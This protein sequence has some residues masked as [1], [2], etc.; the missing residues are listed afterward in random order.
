MAAAGQEI[1]VPAAPMSAVSA[2]PAAG[3]MQAKKDEDQ[4]GGDVKVSDK[5][6][7]SDS[8]PLWK[9][10]DGGEASTNATL[11]A[12]V[13]AVRKQ[14]LVNEQKLNSLS[15]QV[16]KMSG[17]GKS[18]GSKDPGKQKKGAGKQSDMD[19]RIEAAFAKTGG[20]KMSLPKG[21]IEPLASDV[22]SDDSLMAGMGPSK[23]KKGGDDLG[24]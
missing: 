10:S 23:K 7:L 15:A 14:V 8:Q 24:W 21:G 4:F 18:S 22:M 11:D 1:A 13:D 2:A 12:K 16:N 20:F 9:A 17:G 19:A 6:P 5:H 3:P